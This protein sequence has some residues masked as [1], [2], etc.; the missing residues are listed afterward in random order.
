M[1][2]TVEPHPDITLPHRRSHKVRYAVIAVLCI[3][4]V[5]WMLV[6]MTKN[7]VFFKTVSVAVAERAHDGTR[8]FRIGGAVVPGTIHNTGDGAE[9]DLTQGGKTVTVDHHG[10][11]PTLFKDC[12]PVVADG[13]WSGDTFVSNQILI[14]HGSAYDPKKDVKRATAVCPKD[15]FGRSSS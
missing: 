13:H 8:E 11:E 10:T 5:A 4:A 9:F 3:G 2:D 14:K 1:V 12:A 15:P 6:L 7:V